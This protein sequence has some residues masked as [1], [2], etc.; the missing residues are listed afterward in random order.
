MPSPASIRAALLIATALL[1]GAGNSRA[2]EITVNGDNTR[3]V[4]SGTNQT[5]AVLS[6]GTGNT[7]ELQAGGTL[8]GNLLAADATGAA[9]FVS[10]TAAA[11]TLWRAT[12]TAFLSG[13]AADTLRVASGTLIVSGN[14][15]TDSTGA[16]AAAGTAAPTVTIDAAAT[17]QLAGTGTLGAAAIVNNGTL[18]LA[19]NGTSYFTQ[20]VSGAG[21]I[22]SSTINWLLGT[23]THTGGI[24]INASQL[25]VQSPDALGTGTVHIAAGD[26]YINRFN[27]ALPGDFAFDNPLSSSSSGRVIVRL[28]T[29]V[30]TFSFG[31]ATA[32]SAAGFIGTFI[33]Q[34]GTYN[35]DANFAAVT[36]TTASFRWDKD[37]TLSFAP[38]PQHYKKFDISTT[39]SPG[40]VNA[41]QILLFNIDFSNPAGPVFPQILLDATLTMGSSLPVPVKFANTGAAV[42]APPFTPSAPSFTNLLTLD[43]N[44]ADTA[45]W[46]GTLLRFTSGTI[47]KPQLLTHDPSAAFADPA[48]AAALR[49]PFASATT[50]T[51]NFLFGYLTDANASGIYLKYGVA[52]LETIAGKTITLAG[53]TAA[54][55]AA[56]WTLPITGS[57]ALQINATNA[58][59]LTSAFNSFSGTAT[60]GTGTL[61]LTGSF[62][63][64][65]IIID[66]G[67]TL[68]IGS[69]T[70][71]AAGA[72]TPY[73][74]KNIVLNGALILAL[75][76]PGNTYGGDNGAGYRAIR[77]NI[78][79]TGALTLSAGR[80]K[81]TG[82][83]SFSG[84][85]TIASSSLEEYATTPAALGTGTVTI[86][87]GNSLWIIPDEPG[88]HLWNQPLNTIGTGRVIFRLADYNDTL[89]FAPVPAGTGTGDWSRQSV[90]IQRG[91]FLV[92]GGAAGLLANRYMRMDGGTVLTIAPGQQHIGS[93]AIDST[94]VTPDDDALGRT[95][96]F[97]ADFSDPQN[98]LVS[99]LV[100]GAIAWT[101]SARNVT[102][103]LDASTPLGTL[104]A[105]TG[106][107]GN[108]L[109]LDDSAAGA[110]VWTGTLLSF[111][112]DTLS[113]AELAR[114]T[115]DQQLYVQGAPVDAASPGPDILQNG[116]PVAR[117]LYGYS[118]SK[119]A[120]GAYLNAG[121]ANLEVLE[122][123]TLTLD[124]DTTDTAGA[125]ELSLR[126]TGPGNLLVNATRAIKITNEANTLAGVTIVGTGTLVLT[127]KL[128]GGVAIQPG[129]TLQIGDGSATGDPGAFIEQNGT[130]LIRRSTGTIAAGITG[131]GAVT[132]DH[133]TNIWLTGTNT[134]S[135]GLTLAG[136]DASF[137]LAGP[138]SAGTGDITM[139]PNTPANRISLWFQPAAGADRADYIL[140]NKLNW[141]AANSRLLLRLPNL[142]DTFTFANPASTFDG[143][144][145]AQRGT[146]ELNPGNANIL[147]SA[148][149]IR[150]DLGSTL[151][152]PAGAD[153]V[154]R[155]IEFSQTSGGYA[156][157]PRPTL[158]LDADF[159]GP[160]P[161]VTG[162]L[163]VTE[164]LFFTTA[165]RI[166]LNHTG[167]IPVPAFTTPDP[168]TNIFDFD[169]TINSVSTSTKLIT[170]DPDAALLG[171]VNWLSDLQLLGADGHPLAASNT[172]AIHQ[173]GEEI[174]TGHAN[175]YI[176]QKTDG[177]HLDYGFAEITLAD[178]KTLALA[179]ETPADHTLAARL[180]GAG[181][182]EIAATGK[183]ALATY[184]GESDLSGTLT[185]RSGTLQFATSGVL[186]PNATF[187]ADPAATAI[188]FNYTNQ[189]IGV[190]S[191][192]ENVPSNLA[193]GRL[194]I[195]TG[196]TLAGEI[197]GGGIITHNG[198]QNLVLSADNKN[199]DANF[200][201]AGAGALVL[202]IP[203]AA[204]TGRV[205]GSSNNARILLENIAAGTLNAQVT[206]AGILSLDNST[207]TIAKAVTI[208][209]LH[210]QGSDVT[211]RHADGLYA[212]RAELSRGTLFLDTPSHIRANNLCLHP[213]ATLAFVP[214]PNNAHGTLLVSQLE[215]LYTFPDDTPGAPITIKM[216][217]DLTRPGAANSI[218]ITQSVTGDYILD[219][220]NTA[221]NNA[222]NPANTY[223]LVRA[224]N[225][226][227]LAHFTLA[228]TGT[229]EAGGYAWEL[230][231]GNPGNKNTLLNDPNSAYLAV[232]A[233]TPLSRTAQAAL[234]A[235][236]TAGVEWHHTL[237]SLS[238]RLGDIRRTIENTTQNT[239][240]DT[241]ARA[242]HAQLKA[243][244]GLTGAAYDETISHL[245][246]GLDIGGRL[247]TG[248]NTLILG[249]SADA[250]YID[251]DH[252]DRGTGAT[253]TRTLALA[254]TWLHENGWFADLALAST[255]LTNRFHA[256]ALD[257]TAAN[258]RYTSNLTS[259]SL[260]A[261]RKITLP[262]NYWLEPALQLARARFARARCTTDNNIT[263][264]A[265]AADALQARA[266]LRAG[267]DNPRGTLQPHARLSLARCDADPVNLTAD[268]ALLPRPVN[269]TATRAEFAAGADLIISKKTLLH[270][271]Y[272]YAAAKN[273]TRPWSLT[274]TLRHVW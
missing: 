89:A 81:L 186:S 167:D 194:T 35:L 76:A 260:E 168:A 87:T 151:R 162:S 52:A 257:H 120:N 53:D 70:A 59:A 140:D 207:V 213:T 10:L 125:D 48:L 157:D 266:T 50:G 225:P 201:V 180:T 232:A 155:N 147:Q 55:G 126:L 108:I 119:D 2:D 118:L 235:A 138:K 135:G 248:G 44:L 256:L 96:V 156:S 15:I 37:T 40:P 258:A 226:E 39:N 238:N 72:V 142:A 178:G 217:A 212:T 124:N 263:I 66:N 94:S 218:I 215:P 79:G 233:A 205:S 243:T 173:N 149:S 17:L 51:G 121:L 93:L 5:D 219:I 60:I 193:S 25:H 56:D 165:S 234:A 75:G 14:L 136:S 41:Q 64:G 117:P 172:F 229:L 127:G 80:V 197:T 166:Q 97:D 122:N 131:A 82:S 202:A 3:F 269:H 91:N 237:D 261:G 99:H 29:P 230:L 187:V 199:L 22:V 200:Y 221:K 265:D 153:I 49:A 164:R 32:A 13:T 192:P 98:T 169:D 183:I 241:W 255:R 188:D 191:I 254:A 63:D 45:V 67:A 251:R 42:A 128:P 134:F 148:A 264:T 101:N 95:I 16:L 244:A 239:F 246:A 179:N 141:S 90:I 100:L 115:L 159:T 24:R 123:K 252:D 61:V 31:P 170:V 270:L 62:G 112:A 57:G 23:N 110:A 182:V 8:A 116:T 33:G 224:P 247:G 12:G 84:G 1:A 111:T 113:T 30:D 139:S 271:E 65:T 47:A 262:K 196:G 83:N 273:Y 272:E 58:I 259:L 28:A 214:Q 74:G 204:G 175:Y 206:G 227:D 106:A 198:S 240:T 185:L 130:L 132:L 160:V 208:A 4:L 69:G 54:A 137:Y 228:G 216:T 86:N 36:A 158:V 211:I 85:L 77:S 19:R 267:L 27:D 143:I 78:S 146:I 189:T 242:S 210:M 109:T 150:L 268:A 152:V 7:V 223:R 34:I 68:Q 26:L 161:M 203:E 249:L 105:G 21:I 103:R 104:S 222:A 190:I 114:V 236:A 209:N 171:S 195:A 73:A 253:N 177:L 18:W 9:D 144:F 245:A 154:L 184:R 220:A 145:I 6:A 176:A 71:P 11:S 133:G 107:T 250:G 43:E 88:D 129:A 231:P 38:V 102:L 92:T 20:A 163:R 46:T 274:A 181:N 174:A